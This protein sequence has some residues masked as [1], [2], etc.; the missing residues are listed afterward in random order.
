M[1]TFSIEFGFKETLSGSSFYETNKV[2]DLWL[3]RKDS[4]IYSESFVDQWTR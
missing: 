2:K 4:F 1:N 3:K